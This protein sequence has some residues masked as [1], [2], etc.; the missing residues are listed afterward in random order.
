[1]GTIACDAPAGAAG[2]GGSLSPRR[3]AP[4]HCVAPPNS[5]LALFQRHPEILTY[6][7][8]LLPGTKAWLVTPAPKGHETDA[9][10][11][12]CLGLSK[13][14]ELAGGAHRGATQ[15]CAWSPTMPTYRIRGSHRPACSQ[16]AARFRVGHVTQPHDRGLLCGFEPRPVRHCSPFRLLCLLVTRR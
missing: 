9:G 11:P 4:P 13:L 5:C 3:L 1:M 15:D 10:F 16:P 14:G 8:P 7:P 6:P 2:L 12:G